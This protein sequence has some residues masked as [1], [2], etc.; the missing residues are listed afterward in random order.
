M[1]GALSLHVSGDASTLVDYKFAYIMRDDS[2]SITEAGVRFY[3]GAMVTEAQ[4][5]TDGSTK[6]VTYYK[7]A[8]RIAVFPAALIPQ[9]KSDSLGDPLIV[10]TADTFGKIKTDDELRL[11][12]N[13]KLADIAT[14][15]GLSPIPE[16]TGATLK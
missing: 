12:L 15:T 8:Q 9:L 16:Q 1:A 14:F 2:G 7:R 5:Q 13:G 11:F 10:F 4:K 6:N 3:Q